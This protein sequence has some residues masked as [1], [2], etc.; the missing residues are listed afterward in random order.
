MRCDYENYKFCFISNF[1]HLVTNSFEQKE[2]VN[3]NN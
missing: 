2:I 3:E 1:N